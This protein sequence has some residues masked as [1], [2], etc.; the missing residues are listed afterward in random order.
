MREGKERERERERERE[1]RES[2]ERG[3][4]I[5]LNVYAAG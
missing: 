5:S 1:L 2:R 4:A 3:G